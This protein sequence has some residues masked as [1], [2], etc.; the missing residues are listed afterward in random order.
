MS[1]TELLGGDFAGAT[2]WDRALP[3]LVLKA[4]MDVDTV[5]GTADTVYTVDA[6]YGSIR[7]QV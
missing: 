3:A 6:V 7:E 1:T 5:Y 2:L 4:V